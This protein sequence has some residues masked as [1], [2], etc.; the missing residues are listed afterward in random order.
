MKFPSHIPKYLIVR[1]ID[2]WKPQSEIYILKTNKLKSYLEIIKT[3]E[4]LFNV[5]LFKW[6]LDT[7][8]ET[9]ASKTQFHLTYKSL[10]YSYNY[11]LINC[12]DN[13]KT[14]LATYPEII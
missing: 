8:F 11:E 14:L 2:D 7:K 9:K 5:E 4:T 10:K 3:Y 13:M 12:F 1:K 6:L